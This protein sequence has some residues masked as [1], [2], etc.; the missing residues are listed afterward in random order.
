MSRRALIIEESA[1]ARSVLGILL[2]RRGWEVIGAADGAEAVRLASTW[3]FDLVIT[4]PE[5]TK[6]PGL[7]LIQL[8]KGDLL[9]PRVRII[10]QLEHH[11]A[12]RRS[13]FLGLVDDFLFK[14]GQFDE[15]LCSKL[16][17]WFR[18]S[19]P[20][21]GRLHARAAAANR[22]V[23]GGIDCRAARVL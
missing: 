5:P 15:Q 21:I 9:S 18:G 13:A 6:V 8:L 19:A 16:S 2:Q 7:Q 14:N 3:H 1:I 22:R 11:E 4:V 23:H 17:Q 12:V 10:L 20:R